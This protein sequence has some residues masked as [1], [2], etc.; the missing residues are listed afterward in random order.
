MTNNE[1]L[2]KNLTRISLVYADFN[3]RDAKNAKDASVEPDK[4][5]VESRQGTELLFPLV[6]QYLSAYYTVI[7]APVF[8][9][10]NSGGYPF[11]FTGFLSSQ[12]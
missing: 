5:K 11:F 7:P 9:G 12:E 1:N 8:T 6:F 3:A 10:I 4:R 2:K